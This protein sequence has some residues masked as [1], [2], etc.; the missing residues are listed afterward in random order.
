ML[1]PQSSLFPPAARKGGGREARAVEINF[2]NKD[3][4]KG[5]D[6][7]TPWKRRGLFEG[8]LFLKK[9]L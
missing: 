9:P 4:Q 1:P 7:W 3:F 2:K 5:S 8:L 6:F